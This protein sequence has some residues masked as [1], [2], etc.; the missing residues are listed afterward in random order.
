[1]KC[2]SKN[3]KP[4]KIQPKKERHRLE[5][6]LILS[7]LIFSI[8]DAIER[9]KNIHIIDNKQAATLSFNSALDHNNNFECRFSE[10]NGR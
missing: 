5:F 8:S 1:M 6:A 4:V 2:L 9:H 7:P 3:N 10:R